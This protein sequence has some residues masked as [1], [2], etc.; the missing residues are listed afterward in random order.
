MN[1]PYVKQYDDNGVI[2]NPIIGKYVN[3]FLSRK[4]RRNK[5]TRFLNNSNSTQMV[6]NGGR[7][8]LKSLQLETD[9]E[10]NLKHIYHYVLKLNK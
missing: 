10:G 3:S 1:I 5:P 7:R 6:V 8:Y 2:T 9:K 4:A